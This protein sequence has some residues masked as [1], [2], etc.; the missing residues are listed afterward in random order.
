MHAHHHSP[1]PGTVRVGFSVGSLDQ[2]HQRKPWKGLARAYTGGAAEHRKKVG[3]RHRSGLSIS[4]IQPSTLP[5]PPS[6]SLSPSFICHLGWPRVGCVCVCTLA[7]SSYLFR[8]PNCCHAGPGHF[9]LLHERVV[10]GTG[11]RYVWHELCTPRPGRVPSLDAPLPFWAK[12]GA[13]LA[14]ASLASE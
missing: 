6:L 12:K 14:K 10:N 11:P 7:G 4:S 3:R 5:P 13:T 9:H 8:C 2:R 1:W